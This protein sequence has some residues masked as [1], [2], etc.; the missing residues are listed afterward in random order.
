MPPP[1]DCTSISI[2]LSLSLGRRRT[3]RRSTAAP[4]STPT[5][6]LHPHR[7]A[8]AGRHAA[9]VARSGSSMVGPLLMQFG[10]DGAEAALPAARSSRGDEVWCQGYSEPNA[11]S[12]LASLQ[13]AR[14]G[15]RQRQLRRQRP[16]DLDH[17]RPVR[18]L[19]LLPGAHRSE[20]EEAGGHQLPAHRHEDARASTVKPMLTIGGTPAFCETFF[21]NVR[22]AEGEPGRPAQRRL[23]PG[24]GAARPRA[25]AHRRGRRSRARAIRRVKRIAA[26]TTRATAGRCSTIPA[27]R[28][29]DRAPRDPAAR[30]CRW[31]TTARSP[32]RSSGKAPGPESSILKL[33][34]SEILQQALRAGD[35]AS[36]ATTRSPGSTSRAWCRRSSSGCRPAFC[37]TRATT[38]YGGSNEIQKN[39]IAKLHPR[40]AGR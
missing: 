20:R 22:G 9:A 39:I 19:D 30:R 37:Y 17:L 8:R 25:H 18:R 14:R 7:G 3:G 1:A 29:Q 23:D 40:P 6:P 2:S 15:R 33:R 13:H 27:L 34:G 4:G 5:A 11:G 36:W 16:E 21:D 31:R 35:G 32:A 10:N 28:A 24:Q 38:I 12:D 26:G